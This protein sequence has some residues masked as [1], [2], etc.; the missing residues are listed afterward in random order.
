MAVVEANY[1]RD[2]HTYEE[3]WEDDRSAQVQYK[4]KTDDISDGAA[5]VSA[6]T[7][8]PQLGS[9]YSILGE[10]DEGIY[11]TKR[12]VKPLSADRHLKWWLVTD[13]YEK[14]K[15]TK[16]TEE[17]EDNP[18][19]EPPK[20]RLGFE[21]RN[22]EVWIDL[23]GKPSANS[24][25]QP[26]DP[27]PSRQVSRAVVVI[28]RNEAV[29]PTAKAIRYQDAV[30]LDSVFG[31]AP[32]LA[33]MMSITG[34]VQYTDDCDPFFVVTYK[35]AFDRKG[36]RFRQVDHGYAVKELENGKPTGELTVLTDDDGKPLNHPVLLDGK[37]QRL[38]D[39]D[40][41]V[42]IEFQ[43]YQ[44]LPFGPLNL[45]ATLAG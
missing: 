8:L 10:T 44:E 21:T 26:L 20:M 37:G 42:A 18:L 29:D 3:T 43:H 13:S 12:K 7:L 40:A 31:A 2:G 30:A 5:L 23:N 4:V 32:G 35:I 22:E 16:C 39:D 25:G 11:L 45:P 38:D 19:E 36:W 9:V 24:A 33:K 14:R 15:R 6:S 17:Q 28:T 34:E 27:F 1:F 41:P